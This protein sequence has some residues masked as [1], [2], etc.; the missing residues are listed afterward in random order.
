[1]FI[2]TIFVRKRCFENQQFGNETFTSQISVKKRCCVLVKNSTLFHFTL[3]WHFLCT[4]LNEIRKFKYF[5]RRYMLEVY[6]SLF[7]QIAFCL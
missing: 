6:F 3:F 5:R 2:L 4:G 7:L 1:M